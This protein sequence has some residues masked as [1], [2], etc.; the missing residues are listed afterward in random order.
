MLIEQ[1][2]IAKELK[3]LKAITSNS[4]ITEA[5]GILFKNNMLTANNLEITV[6]SKLAV[7]TD[8]DEEFVI[9]LKAI[10]YIESLPAG[11]IEITAK[12]NRLHIKGQHGNSSFITVGVEEITQYVASD[13]I[14]KESTF[15]Y[16][17]EELV[18]AI[19]KV[20]Y[21]CSANSSRPVM[22]G[23]LLRGDGQH[24]NIVACDGFRLAWNQIAC[25]GEINVVVPKNT[26]QKFLSLGLQGNIKLYALNDKKAVFKT[27]KYAVYTQLLT[28][29]YIN[30]KPL[31][32][33]EGYNTKVSV[34][35]LE[36]LESVARS[37][38]CSGKGFA[39]TTLESTE[40][41]NLA[42][43]VNSTIADFREV[44][45]VFSDID[46]K[47]KI[48]FNPRYLIES[49]KASDEDNID[50]YYKS[51]QKALWML[52]GSIKQLVLPVRM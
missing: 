2:E 31:F 52:D 22:N 21:A 26:I 32:D 6:T 30:Y 17:S 27:E 24:L 8:E 4:K 47:I 11:K 50:I 12:N 36:L 51:E 35:R 13:V 46:K 37:V 18:E 20:L 43:T 1:R 14:E 45:D 15:E 39:K 19:N 9:P 33:E 10:D 38:L 41:G 40:D 3:K 7:D 42:I 23:V 25:E 44:V 34:K 48:S 29:D 49:L 16:N 5:N 28:G